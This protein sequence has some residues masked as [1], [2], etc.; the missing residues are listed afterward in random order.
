LVHK[1]LKTGPEF[2]PTITI[3]FCHSPSYTLYVAFTL[4]PTVTLNDTTSGLSAAQIWSPKC[5]RIGRP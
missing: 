5:Y 3:L 1:W 2:L 4:R